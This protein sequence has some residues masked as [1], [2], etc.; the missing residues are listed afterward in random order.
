MLDVSG[1]L[2]S[3]IALGG[4][5]RAGLL[6]GSSGDR[7]R[8]DLFAEANH[9]FAGDTTTWVRAGLEQRVVLTRNTALRFD[10][11]WNR[12]FGSDWAEA[13]LRFDILF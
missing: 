3:D 2:D 7:W 10:A 12:D 1:A 13:G 11:S 5:G 8:V 4:G 9:F 6:V